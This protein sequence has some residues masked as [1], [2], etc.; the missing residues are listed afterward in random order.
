MV[1]IG[2]INLLNPLDRDLELCT[3]VFSIINWKIRT[4]PETVN[5]STPVNEELKFL[6]DFVPDCSE[7]VLAHLLGVVRQ[8][9]LELAGVLVHTFDL[10]LVEVDPEVVRVHLELLAWGFGISGWLL[11][12][13]SKSV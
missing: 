6:F 2:G 1:T 3:F 8:L 12:E 7:N 10:L 5:A 13:K 9:W 11:W 4:L